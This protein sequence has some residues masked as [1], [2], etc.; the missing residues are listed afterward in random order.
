MSSPPI[1][2][3]PQSPESRQVPVEPFRVAAVQTVS[4]P[5][6]GRNLAECAALIA[7]AAAGGARLVGLPEYFGIIGMRDRDKV[8]AREQPGDGPIQN[9]LAETARRHEVWLVGGSV[10]LAC[11]DPDKVWNASLVFD[12]AGRCVAR[13]DKIHLFGFDNGREKYSEERTIMHGSQVVTVDSPFGRIGLSICYDLRFPE[14][15]RSFGDVDLIFVPSAFTE[16]TGDAHWEPLLRARAIENL[17]YVVAPAQGGV[18]PNGRETHG[19]SMVVDP[20]GRILAQQ[21]KGPG[22]VLAD[23]DPARVQDARSMLP[24]LSH[25]TLRSVR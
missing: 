11:D 17:A 3:Q 2:P 18:H 25:R 20:W 19:H 21:A 4:G 6:V 7:E 5:D 15:Y 13:Y 12:D 8:V 14:L 24:A 22:V 23:V 9:F 1:Q 10:P 16:T